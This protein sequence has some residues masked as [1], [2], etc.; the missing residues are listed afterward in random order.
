MRTTLDIDDDVLSAL[1]ELARLRGESIGKVVS[2]AVR[3][4]IRLDLVRGPE[5]NGGLHKVRESSPEDVLA[6]YGFEPLP[7]R[8]K[9]VTNELINQ[10][11]D[12][13][14]L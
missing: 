5:G 14:G 3:E 2:E 1:K 9:L 4:G 7:Y 8:G 12:D 11:R 10:I 6:K 13:E